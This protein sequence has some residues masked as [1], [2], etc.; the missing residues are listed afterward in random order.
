MA[1]GYGNIDFLLSVKSV[2]VCYP[3]ESL[4]N[5]SA[6]VSSLV[7]NAGPFP[8]GRVI[9]HPTVDKR[10]FLGIHDV[11]GQTALHWKM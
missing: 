1:T 11:Q 8:Q 3:V 4:H 10:A 6:S 5:S 9:L 2:Q 7:S